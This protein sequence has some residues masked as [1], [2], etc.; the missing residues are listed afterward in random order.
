MR[1]IGFLLFCV[2]L[3]F[4][5]AANAKGLDIQEV[6]SKGGLTAWLVEDHSIP[7]IALKFAFRD[8]GS[9]NDGIEKQGLA[10][11]AS[12]T[13]DEGAGDLDSQAFQK[14]LQD[15]SITLRFSA[16]R[17]NFGGNVKTLS[18][19]KT[20]AFALL[21]IALM[22]PRFD[23]E[24]L[25]RMRVSNESRIKSALMDPDWMAAR[26][27]NDKIFDGT[28]YA[29]NSGGTLSSLKTITAEDLK[30]FHKTL[31]RKALVVSVAGDMTPD[32]L[33]TLL[34]DVFGGMPEGNLMDDEPFS[35]KNAG[36]T[37]LYK[38][39]IPQTMIE[40]AQPGL[41]R[42]DPDYETAQVMNFILGSSGFGSRLMDEVREK[43]GLTY[44]IY[45]YL[46]T[47]V[48][49]NTLQVSTSTANENT[50]EVLSLIS[51]EWDK[52]KD[53]LVSDKELSDAKS[54]LIGSLPLALTSTD[55]IAG[56]LMTLQLERLPIDY[57]DQRAERINAV[58]KE[59]VQSISKRLL[60]TKDFTTILVGNPPDAKD[61]TIV[62]ALPNVE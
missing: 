45:T 1:Q 59:D 13:M 10:R 61:A 31:G 16:D 35:L 28:P 27:Q 25:Q 20:R 41:E 6:R 9:K 4:S 62:E 48:D 26:L 32:E 5:N 15:L 38:Q 29:L 60:N 7:V 34:D 23:A 46:Q 56:L 55:S 57:L 22:S 39:D 53:T 24:P 2:A 33:S 49:T 18:R 21:K 30:A 14:E 51:Q 47:Y 11:L 8:A 50:A 36:A 3:L 52:M 42:N 43:R 17:D 54:Y 19:N 44:G 37:Y 12:N 58:T 40:I